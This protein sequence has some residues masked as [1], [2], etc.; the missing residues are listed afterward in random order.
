[1]NPETPSPQLSLRALLGDSSSFL[2]SPQF[3]RERLLVY[4]LARF[5]VALAIVVGAWFAP[6][7]VGIEQLSVRGLHVLA[8]C[9]FLYNTIIF[10]LLYLSSWSS[11]ASYRQ[12]ILIMHGAIGLDFVFLTTALWLVG[13]VGSPFSSF[14]ILHI[15]LAGMLLPRVFVLLHALF[16]YLLFAGLALGQWSGMVPYLAPTGA[17]MCDRHFDHRY[18]I[19]TLV[20]HAVLF[21]VTALLVSE[22]A[23]ALKRGESALRT[24]NAELEQLSSMRRDFLHVIAH[25]LKAPTAAATMMLTTVEQ[26]WGPSAPEEAQSALKR[27]RERI[28]ELGSLIQ[29]LQQ[30]NSLESGALRKHEQAM[31]LNQTARD[32]ANEYRDLAAAKRLTIEMQLEPSLPEV[33]A[34]PRLIHEAAANYVT[35][36]IKYT[37]EGGHITLRTRHEDTM[38]LFEVEDTGVGVPQEHVNQLFGEFVRA[39]ARVDGRRPPG[40]GLGLSIVK[41]IMHYYGGRV[42]VTSTPGKGSVFGFALPAAPWAPVI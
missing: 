16:G 20:V 22:M 25:N 29:D 10:S 32:L 21:I 40:I 7:I 36:A 17:V 2:A 23:S 15:I 38:V 31:D 39:P 8:A 41:R 9:L 27:A 42:Y 5:G 19:T 37:P 13:G 33:H 35:N 28:Q 34:V 6:T 26:I 30:L 12:L 11:P 14:Y 3:L 1:M 18:A 4:S 24:L